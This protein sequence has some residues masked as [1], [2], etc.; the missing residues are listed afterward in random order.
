MMGMIVC[1]IAP[2]V[3][4]FLSIMHDYKHR[5]RKHVF[6]RI[7]TNAFVFV[8]CAVLVGVMLLMALKYSKCSF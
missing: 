5:N 8:G 7:V 2:M 4:A 1:A 6:N 3:I